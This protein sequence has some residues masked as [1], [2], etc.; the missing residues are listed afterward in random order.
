MKARYFIIAG[1]IALFSGCQK[2]PEAEPEKTNSYDFGLTVRNEDYVEQVVLKGMGNT[3][4]VKTNNLPSWITEV[5]LSKEGYE[6]DPVALFSIKADYNMEESRTAK[7]SLE[8]SSGKTATVE[9]TQWPVLQAKDNAIYKS[10]NTKF[11][12]NWSETKRITLVTS[13]VKENGV[14]DIKSIDVSL[15][16]NWDQMPQCYLPKG[17]GSDESMEVYKMIDRKGDWS[18]VFNLTGINS[19][20]NYNYFGLYNRYTGILRIFYYF[21]EEMIPDANVSDHLWS[22]SVNRNLASHIATQFALPS[23]EKPTESFLTRAA[24]PVLSSPTTDSFNP[25]SSGSKNVPAVGWWAFDVNMA[26]YRAGHNF[27]DESPRNAVNIN[28]CTYNEQNVVLNSVIKGAING[29]LT[30]KVNL[31]AIRPSK[32]SETGKAWTT[33]LG[34]TSTVLTHMFLINETAKTAQDRISG[35]PGDTKTNK[36]INSKAEMGDN[37]LLLGIAPRPRQSNVDTKSFSVTGLVLFTVGIVSNIVG[38]IIE[39]KCTEKVKDESFGGLTADVCMDLDAVMATQGVIGA[40]T[41]NKVPPV[42]MSMEYLKSETPDKKPTSLGSGVWNLAKHPVIYVVKDAYWSENN[43]SVFSSKKE[44]PVGEGTSNVQDVYSYDIGATKGSRPGLRLITFLDPTSVRGVAFNTDLFDKEFQSLSVYLSYGVYPSSQ[45]G[46]TDAFRI[47]EGLDYK[48]SW[49]LSEK[50]KFKSTDPDCGFKLFKKPHTDELFNWVGIEKDKVQVAGYRLSNQ[51]LRADRPGL[52]RRYYGPS[53]YYSKPYASAFDLDDVQF[54]YDPQ[55]Y[56]PFNETGHT[57]YDPQIPDF[58]VTAAIN[59]AGRDTRDDGSPMAIVTSTLRYLPKIEFISY[60]DVQTVYN[61]I[62]ARKE[63]MYGP[64]GT[65][66]YFVEMEYL[67][68]HIKDIAD[69]LK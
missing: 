38:K 1:I 24:K 16:W 62:K 3:Y 46:Y 29:T 36:T 6:G 19:L 13:N 14:S 43:F 67:V 48:H 32:L 41:A 63:E 44:Y 61:Q 5:T 40:P 22:F 12:D 57:L 54:V 42:S 8:M 28:L 10:M 4:I 20:P 39:S 37:D 35:K 60:K 65:N 55:V 56:V 66:T 15:P 7:V 2:S 53:T 26:A 9:L 34:I 58:V 45:P 17:D 51:Y 64:E 52:E 31:E 23:H 11:E 68:N 59:A 21:T 49:R 69:A 30:G 33:A 47:D 27:F 25:L 18:L 50:E